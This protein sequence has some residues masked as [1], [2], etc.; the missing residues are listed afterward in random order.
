MQNTPLNLDD[1]RPTSPVYQGRLR[2]DIQNYK[3]HGASGRAYA[4]LVR[5]AKRVAKA[6]GQTVEEIFDQA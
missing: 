5:R 3:A 1:Y 6:T 4:D 2:E